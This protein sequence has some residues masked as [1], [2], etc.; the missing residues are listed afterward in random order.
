MI[1]IAARFTVKPEHADQWPEL[2]RAFT[3]ATRAEPG[4]LWFDWSRSLDDP[5]EYVLLEAFT[6]DGAEPHVGS[7]HFRT[8][9]EELPRYLQETP[10]VRNVQLD[11]EGWDELGE[12][13]VR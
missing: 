9:T 3:E 5:N 11:G 13:A 2:T 12:M 7:D 6:D 10:R 1:F 4:N 8:A